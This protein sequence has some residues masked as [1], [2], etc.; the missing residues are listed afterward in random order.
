MTPRPLRSFLSLAVVLAAACSSG[1]PEPGAPEPPDPG[2]QRIL[3]E[4]EFTGTVSLGGASLPVTM[5]MSGPAGRLIATFRIPDL[6]VV[7]NGGGRLADGRLRLELEYGSECRGEITLDGTATDD[8]R[9]VEGRVTANDCT[10]SESGT[11]VLRG[12]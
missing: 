7:A 5:R 8:V 12:S 11:F 10:G 9:R 4:R 6:D 3:V 1:A 2:G